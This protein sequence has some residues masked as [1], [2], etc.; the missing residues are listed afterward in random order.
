MDIWPP[1]PHVLPPWET[2]DV[3]APLGSSVSASCLG[4][5]LHLFSEPSLLIKSGLF[6]FLTL[7]GL[8]ILTVDCILMTLLICWEQEFRSSGFPSF[9]LALNMPSP[10][11]GL[12]QPLHGT[13]GPQWIVAL[14]R[15]YTWQLFSPLQ[16][17]LGV[18]QHYF[19]MQPW[20]QLKVTVPHPFSFVG[21]R[22]CI[23]GL[24]LYF[25]FAESGGA[26]I[27]F[28]GKS[29]RVTSSHH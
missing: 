5:E 3:L 1:A 29:C 8:N 18:W 21:N 27:D 23:S 15:P 14:S 12:A 19:M 2:A 26:P 13:L 20:I 22:F 10:H 25:W 4:H 7:A 11:C 16:V 24:L 28:G 9:K 17:R 6:C